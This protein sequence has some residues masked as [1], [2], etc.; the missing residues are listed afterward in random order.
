MRQKITTATFVDKGNSAQ[1]YAVV[2]VF[3]APKLD[4]NAVLCVRAGVERCAT[5]AKHSAGPKEIIRN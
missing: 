3:Y 4:T 1:I 5:Q 2:I